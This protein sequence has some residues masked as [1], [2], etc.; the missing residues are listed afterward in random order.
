MQAVT[1]RQVLRQIPQRITSILALSLNQRISKTCTIR[2]S[3]SVCLLIQTL[4]CSSFLSIVDLIYTPSYHCI[5]Q[6]I[7]EVN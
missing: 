5:L 7:S 2:V 6:E 3:E 1:R 4:K